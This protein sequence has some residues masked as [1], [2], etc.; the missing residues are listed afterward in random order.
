MSS[1]RTR[2]GAHRLSGVT[3]EKERRAREGG[4]GMRGCVRERQVGGERGDDG[5][6]ISD[7]LGDLSRT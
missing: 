1:G 3:L 4:G 5:A 2:P 6:D 7:T